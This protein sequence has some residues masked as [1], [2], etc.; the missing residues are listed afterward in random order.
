MRSGRLLC[1]TFVKEYI[2]DAIRSEGKP[3]KRTPQSVT[4]KRNT[5]N[6]FSTAKIIW[7]I[8]INSSRKQIAE[9][10]TYP[11]TTVPLSLS[12]IDGEMHSVPKRT[13]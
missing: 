11:L 3:I 2:D 13:N 1:S 5:N 10:F 4:T 8:I 7:E 12:K 6:T 9:V